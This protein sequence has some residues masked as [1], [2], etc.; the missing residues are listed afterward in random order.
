VILSNRVQTQVNR[1]QHH[2]KILAFT[3][4]VALLAA[5]GGT[6][7]PSLQT[8]AE[9]QTAAQVEFEVGSTKPQ[10]Y[11]PESVAPVAS[12]LAPEAAPSTGASTGGEPV[13]TLATVTSSTGSWVQCAAEWGTCNFTGSR[14]VRYGADGYF[15]VKGLT[16]P[17]RCSNDVFG[18]PIKSRT[19]YCSLWVTSS[20]AAPSAPAPAPSPSPAPAPGTRA[21]LKQPFASNSIWNMPIGSGAVYT[22]ANISGNPGNNQ[23]ALMP[24]IDDE[25]IILRPSSPMTNLNLSNAAW[26]GKNRCAATGGLLMQVPMPSD[27]I[28]PHSTSN[29]SATFLMPDRRTL[30]QT[31]PVARCTAGAAGTSMAKFSNVD[32]YGTGITGA[33]GGSGLSA[34]GGSIRMGELRPGTTTGP[35]H[36]LKVNVYAKEVL[37]KCTTRSDCYRWPAVTG[38]SYAVGWYG[39]ANGNSNTAVKMG[40]LL[41]IPPSVSIASLGLETEPAKQLAWTLQNYGA[42]IVDDTYAPGFALNAEEGPDGSKKAQFKSDWG[43]DMQ[44]KVANNTPWV[45]DI[46]RLVKALHVVNNNSASSI[47]GGGTPRQSLAPAIAP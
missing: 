28:V 3:P 15:V 21:P 8:S 38:D 30:V 46:Q 12:D 35:R 22:R 40:A 26:T 10:N 6:D 44:Q 14:D 24:G 9:S 47:G 33:H 29:S 31:Q 17:V 32:L 27:Y 43:F 5:C 34:I 23:W 20:T 16:G 1:F 2:S 7:D 13:R 42:Y 37:Y 11:I 25:K 36:A 4:I 45:R 18:D 39:T 19:K 41:A